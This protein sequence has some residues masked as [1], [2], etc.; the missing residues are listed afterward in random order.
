MGEVER[1]RGVYA[2]YDSDSRRRTTWYDSPASRSRKLRKWEAIVDLLGGFARI[3]PHTWVVDLGAGGDTPDSLRIAEIVP[4]LGGIIAVDI[5]HERI[6]GAA[7]ASA[8]L[9]PLVADGARLPLADAS[10]GMVYQS[11]MLSSV[12]RTDLRDAIFAEIRRVL[13]PG[14]LFLSYDARVPNPFNRHTRPVR[15]REQ[16]AAF[17]GWPQ[18]CRSLTDI[19]Q[20]RRILARSPGLCRIVET[21]PVLRSH[22]LFAAVK[23]GG[24]AFGV[25]LGTRNGRWGGLRPG[26]AR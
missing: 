8:L 7:G 24:G 17:A 25:G 26:V 18:A 1:L 14:G 13:C 20:I 10:A 21:V 6:A 19:P 3:P 4:D 16:R 15:L 11:T 12:L 5:L 9:R 23:P 22:R 2:V